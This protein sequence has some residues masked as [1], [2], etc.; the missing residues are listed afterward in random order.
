M[1]PITE[2]WL[3]AS[4]FKYEMPFRPDQKHWSLRLGGA[5]AD[6]PAYSTEDLIVELAQD[7]SGFWFCWI[8]A[9][10]AGR[11]SR[12]VHVRHMNGQEE[13]ALLIT[14]LTGFLFDP[15][16]SYY[17]SYFRP[18]HAARLRAEDQQRL[19]RRLAK[20]WGKRVER[21]TGADPDKREKLHP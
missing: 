8:R 17:G 2:E 6:K 18:E 16:N 13:V 5:V 10:Y 1:N 20:E 19:E 7:P 21:E 14:A 15:A 9:D 12:F 3:R 11:Y 4:G